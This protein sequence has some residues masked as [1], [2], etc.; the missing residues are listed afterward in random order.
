MQSKISVGSGMLWG[1][2]FLQSTQS[3]LDFLPET[4]T[5]FVF[6]V[7]AEEWGFVG[8]AGLLVLYGLI[9][10]RLLVIAWRARERFGALLAVGAAALVFWP[11]LFNIGMNIGVLPVV[12]IPL[13]LVSYGGSSLLT[14]MLV[15]GLALNVSTRR[16]IF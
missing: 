10:T 13:P 1:K 3:R 16:A 6:A 4:H 7:F 8:A 11:T 14:V 9:L 15:M 12:G 5:D 2:G